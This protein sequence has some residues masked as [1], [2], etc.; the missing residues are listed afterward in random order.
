MIVYVSF[1]LRIKNK[2]SANII[3]IFQG[4][5]S[6]E[7]GWVRDRLPKAQARLEK[8]GFQQSEITDV[9][10]ANSSVQ[11]G[12]STADTER[13]KDPKRKAPRSMHPWLH[14]HYYVVVGY[15]GNQSVPRESLRRITE[16]DGLFKQ[17]RKAYRHLRNPLRRVMSLKEVCG[18][19]VYECDPIKGYHK[20]IELDRD[21]QRALTEL[22]RSYR[23]H[24]LDY[25][26]RWL[27]WIH[28]HFNNE[29]KSPEKG[30]LT[31]EFKLRWSA[32]K[33]IF[34]GIMPVLLSLAVGFWYM[35][36]DHGD[37]DDV[38]VAEAAWVIATYIITTSARKFLVTFITQQ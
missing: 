36:S 31:L 12:S 16:I 21:T 4:W 1:S 28:Q 30:R 7:T 24:K 14:E 10:N 27:M 29:S 32:Y 2:K 25:G 11:D 13:Q 6:F 20:E 33:V 9:E 35:Y 38:A 5:F 19:G 17:I 15:M 23:G 37:I 34:W 26:G 18:F 8:M 22:W 3:S